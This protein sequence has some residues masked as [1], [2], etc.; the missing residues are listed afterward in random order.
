MLKNKKQKQNTN[1]IKTNRQT[2]NTTHADK[3]QNCKIRL[4]LF[5]HTLQLRFVVLVTFLTSSASPFD[6]NRFFGSR[7]SNY[8]N[9]HEQKQSNKTINKQQHHNNLTRESNNLCLLTAV[10]IPL[11]E[12]D[13]YAG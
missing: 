12:A 9:T 2:E 11:A 13:R 6:P 10:N 1:T 5:A 3:R 4:C 7:S 8:I